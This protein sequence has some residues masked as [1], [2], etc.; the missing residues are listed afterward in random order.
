MLIRRG[1]TALDKAEALRGTGSYALQAGI[2]ACHARARRPPTPTGP[3]I[4]ALY[5]ILAQ[6]TPNPVIELNRA[7]AH[8]MAFGPAVGLALLDANLTDHP[9]LAGYHLLPSV[10]GDFLKKLGR[11]ERGP[12]R[13]RAR[14]RPHPQ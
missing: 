11:N 12:G 5:D 3:R 1:L 4:A 2:A 6:T 13:I 9:S 14:R 8:A 7:V 10:R